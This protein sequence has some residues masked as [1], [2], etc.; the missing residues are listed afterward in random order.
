MSVICPVSSPTSIICTTMG[1]K[2]SWCASGTDIAWPIRTA[3][4]TSS[5]AAE[6]TALPAVPPTTSNAWRT[7]TPTCSRVERF[8]AQR[9]IASF[10][11]SDPNTGR[12]SFNPST[13]SR[14]AGLLR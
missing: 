1:G 7:G 4:F 6:T 5:I 14:N 12:R 13:F 2:R 11:N 8:R 3:D 9:L 10:L